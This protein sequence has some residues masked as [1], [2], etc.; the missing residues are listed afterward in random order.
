MWRSG[1]VAMLLKSLLLLNCPLS[2]N[3]RN[4]S[5][6]QCSVTFNKSHWKCQKSP[7]GVIS[8]F[9]PYHNHKK[10]VHRIS[11]HTIDKQ[12]W[13]PFS[14]IHIHVIWTCLQA[15]M[16]IP[17]YSVSLKVSTLL[18]DEALFHG[19]GGGCRDG[20]QSGGARPNGDLNFSPF[21]QSLKDGR[22]TF[23]PFYHFRSEFWILLQLSIWKPQEVVKI[24]S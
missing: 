11:H 9:Q 15:N 20:N 12:I 17:V 19:D 6:A 4:I 2:H 13:F 5:R 18:H 7:A 24:K 14:L 23:P 16:C 21:S 8:I 22:I 3:T 10:L 1:D